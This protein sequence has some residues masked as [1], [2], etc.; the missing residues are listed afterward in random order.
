MIKKKTVAWLQGC[1]MI[2]ETAAWLQELSHGFRTVLWLQICH[3][4]LKNPTV[5]WFR[6]CHTISETVVWLQKLSHN[7]KKRRLH[8]VRTVTWSENCCMTSKNSGT[9]EVWHDFKT[10]TGHNFCLW[11]EIC[12][13]HMRSKQS[14]L[15]VI[16]IYTLPNGRFRM[17]CW[18]SYCLF[19]L[20]SQE[21]DVEILWSDSVV[22]EQMKDV[23]FQTM[24]CI[25]CF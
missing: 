2:W 11:P 13:E 18:F 24:W 6:D 10:V 21:F 14:K 9:S 5:L 19:L 3:M 17:S 15:C 8:D 22:T 20:S 23:G 4:V 7:L 1:H 16:V 12:L 25:G